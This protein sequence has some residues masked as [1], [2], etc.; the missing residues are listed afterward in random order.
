MI[1]NKDPIEVLHEIHAAIF[2][3]R[4]QMAVL[5]NNVK[6]LQARLNGDGGRPTLSP[7]TAHLVA[8]PPPPPPQDTPPAPQI[9]LPDAPAAPSNGGA[10]VTGKVLS[11][12]GKPLPSIAVKIMNSDK[13]VI[14]ETTTN[15]A[16]QWIAKLRPGK[17]IAKAIFDNRP[18]QFKMFDVVEGQS[19]L[20]V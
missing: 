1:T 11:D 17:Y 7:T 10:M 14:K 12:E 5:D 6:L 20:D 18:A 8:I 16:G 4:G 15:R 13:K 19:T 3:I 9:S 2:E